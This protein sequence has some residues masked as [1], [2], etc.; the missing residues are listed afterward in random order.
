MTEYEKYSLLTAA[1]SSFVTLLAVGAAI[2]GERIRQ[3]WTQPKLR[4]SL[5]DTTGSLANR[6]DGK[7]GRYYSLNVTNERRSSPAINVR[8]L[9]TEIK[10]RGPDGNWRPVIFSA[11][12]NVTWKWPTITPA[13]ATIG[14]DEM[15]TFGFII[16]GASRFEL[17]LYWRPNNLDPTFPPNEPVQLSFK[18]VSDT[19]ESN[20][21]TVQVAWDGKWEEGTVEMQG[22][23]TINE[24]L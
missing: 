23:L 9:L 13:Y 8:V 4:I 2:W 12:V 17:Q 14:P 7:K 24:V 3:W 1:I 16:E 21:L 22:H 6:T 15:A 19:V 11:P 10:K 5:S 20:S 18:A